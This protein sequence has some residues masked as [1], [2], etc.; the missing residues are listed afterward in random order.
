MKELF[1]ISEAAN[2]NPETLSVKRISISTTWA[3]IVQFGCIKYMYYLESCSE[4]D[5]MYCTKNQY[6]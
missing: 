1:S 5:I 6:Q 4:G 3:V 2:I